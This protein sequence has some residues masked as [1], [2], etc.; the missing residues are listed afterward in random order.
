MYF[1]GSDN[2]DYQIVF[3]DRF[4]C[5]LSHVYK[6]KQLNVSDKEEKFLHPV[7]NVPGFWEQNDLT[8]SI[9]MAVGEYGP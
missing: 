3:Q 9:R 5:H 2:S 7:W 6:R 1:I 4:S 8:N